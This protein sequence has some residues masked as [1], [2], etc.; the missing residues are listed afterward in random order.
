[1]VLTI[2]Y[3]DDLLQTVVNLFA[4]VIIILKDKLTIV[5]N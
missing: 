1:M 2:I 5:C 3:V 4:F